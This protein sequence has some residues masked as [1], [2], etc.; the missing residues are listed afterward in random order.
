MAYTDINI[1]MVASATVVEKE[2]VEVSGSGT[3]APA[4]VDSIKVLGAAFTDAASGDLVAIQTEGIVNT[5]VGTG[6]VT[7]GDL[8]KVAADGVIGGAIFGQEVGIALQTGL[9]T[10]KVDILLK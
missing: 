9:V 7:A 10:E 8:I 5:V 6:G 2:L 3:V 1:P 4:G